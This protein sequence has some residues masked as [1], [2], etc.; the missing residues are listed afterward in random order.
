MG[1]AVADAISNDPSKRPWGLMN[2]VIKAY[3]AFLVAE[4]RGRCQACQEVGDQ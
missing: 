3:A 2:D 1:T 4:P